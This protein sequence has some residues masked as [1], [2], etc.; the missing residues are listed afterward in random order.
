MIPKVQETL[1]SRVHFD[2]S[3]LQLPVYP[4]ESNNTLDTVRWLRGIS[5]ANEL[6]LDISDD[7][8]ILKG[9]D[10]AR[11][12]VILQGK[13]S[14]KFFETASNMQWD[15]F[16]IGGAHVIEYP[17]AHES[18]IETISQVSREPF[19]FQINITL[20]EEDS[21]NLK[22]FRIN[23]LVGLTVSQFDLLRFK[24]PYSMVT[25]PTLSY[26]RSMIDYLQDNTISLS[27]TCVGGDPVTQ[28][29]DK[30]S[31]IITT[32]RDALGQTTSQTVTDFT[33]GFIFKLTA[34]PAGQHVLLEVDL[35]ISSD[36]QKQPNSLPEISRKQVINTGYLKLDEVWSCA[37]FQS[38]DLNTQNG[39]SL[40]LPWKSNRSKDQTLLVT[41][42]RS[43]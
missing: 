41:I 25:T 36:T 2:N 1:G 27:L 31:S 34:Y 21:E 5:L 42:K 4:L 3:L 8:V 38:K 15:I 14:D 11:H 22:G 7:A 12:S 20:I 16:P 28:R 9:K 33:S 43:K 32:S 29:I 40:F 24:K 35:E 19:T 26:D 37:E 39:S 18:L 30:T 17:V 13:L 23:N 10:F 6:Y